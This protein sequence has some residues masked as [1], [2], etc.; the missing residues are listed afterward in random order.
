[1]GVSALQIGVSVQNGRLCAKW[2]SLCKMVVSA[3]QIG[4]HTDRIYGAF[5]STEVTADT[6]S[7][8]FEQWVSSGEFSSCRFAE[9]EASDWT[10]VDADHTRATSVEVDNGF[11]PL[12]AFERLA[13]LRV[14]ILYAVIGA[15]LTASTAINAVSGINGV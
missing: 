8:I 12:G 6:R 15:D 13:E 3:L 1:M 14:L 11:G 5:D 2:S 4:V 10:C 9:C 7:G